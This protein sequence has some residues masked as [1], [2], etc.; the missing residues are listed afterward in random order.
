MISVPLLT[1][2]K[3][4]KPPVVP[5]SPIWRDPALIVSGPRNSEFPVR[6]SLPA[7]ALIKVAVDVLARMSPPTVRVPAATVTVAV[8]LRLTS[9]VPRSRSLVPRKVKFPFQF[10]TLFVPTVMADPKCCR[11]WCLGDRENPAAQSRRMVDVQSPSEEAGSERMRICPESVRMP[12]PAF[13]SS[14]IL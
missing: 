3:L 9:P 14:S 5:P 7:P 8:V 12:V 6:T 13:V 4:L 2:P 10:W 1:T 11:W